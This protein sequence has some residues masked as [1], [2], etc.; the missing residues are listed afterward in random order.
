[1]RIDDYDYE[2]PGELIAQAPLPDRDASRLM[3]LEREHGG[4]EHRRFAEL[5]R[6][7]DPGDLLVLNDTRVLP[8]R[9]LG[10]KPGGGGIE[11]FLLERDAATAGEAWECLLRASRKPPRG[12]RI[13][14]EE[15]LTRRARF[16]W[17]FRAVGPPSCYAVHRRCKPLAATPGCKVGWSAG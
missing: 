3:L 13:R 6:L 5:P 12:S 17:R 1:M 11:V 16:P 4:L 15:Q 8:A 14:F 10:R 2:L 7:L 9:L